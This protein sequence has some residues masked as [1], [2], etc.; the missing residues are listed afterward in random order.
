MCSGNE[1][2][3]RK[4]FYLVFLVGIFLKCLLCWCYVNLSEE[5]R[6]IYVYW[7][8]VK[9]LYNICCMNNNFILYYLIIEIGEI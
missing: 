8:K 3:G 7:K 6:Y 4:E 9:I 5:G 2:R 1:L